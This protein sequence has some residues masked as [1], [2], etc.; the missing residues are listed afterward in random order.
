MMTHMDEQRL[1]RFS[2][3]IAPAVLAELDSYAESHRWSRSTAAAELIERGLVPDQEDP[4][5]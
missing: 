1:V 2:I 5:R 4:A 3:S